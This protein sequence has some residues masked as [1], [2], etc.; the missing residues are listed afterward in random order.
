MSF[1]ILILL[2]TILFK[3]TN[4]KNMLKKCLVS[5]FLFVLFSPYAFSSKEFCGKVKDVTVSIHNNIF[6]KVANKNFKIYE[7]KT[8]LL[9]SAVLTAVQSDKEIC[10]ETSKADDPDP[11]VIYISFK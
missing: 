11:T 8:T 7:N 5:I 2:D 6:F 1:E 9:K 3:Q 10:V 4:G